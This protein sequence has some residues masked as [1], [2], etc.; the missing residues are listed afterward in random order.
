MTGSTN[1]AILLSQIFYW[2]SHMKKE[3]YKTDE[4]FREEIGLT[5]HEFNNAK[6]HIKKLPFITVTVK[7]VPAQ[8]FY[9]VNAHKWLEMM[10]QILNSTSKLVSRKA[11]NSEPESGQLLHENTHEKELTSVASQA[12]QQSDISIF[13]SSVEKPLTDLQKRKTHARWASYANRLKKAVQLAKQ[14]NCNSQIKT[15]TN[16]FWQLHNR[17]KIPYPRISSVLKW[18]CDRMV[19][20]DM[21]MIP[22]A[23]SGRSFRE[24]FTRIE[25]A[26]ER[27]NAPAKVKDGVVPELDILNTKVP[28]ESWPIEMENGERKTRDE[29]FKLYPE[30]FHSDGRL[31]Q[32]GNFGELIN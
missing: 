29:F 13:D 7:K 24:K 15:W 18:Y 22:E 32:F 30:D 4:S 14:S 1:A 17:D 6:K 31:K 2:A 11:D 9:K 12:T 19:N 5:R 16:S 27:C 23:F 3:F 10:Q 21:D 8:T 20:G 28:D 26:I 25:S